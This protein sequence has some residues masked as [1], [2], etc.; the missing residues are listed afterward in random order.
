LLEQYWKDAVGTERF[1]A[2]EMN[3]FFSVLKEKKY[4]AAHHSAEYEKLCHPA[5]RVVSLAFY[6][7][8]WF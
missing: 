7:K 2:R 6:P 4:L 1:S 3:D 5:Y 8:T